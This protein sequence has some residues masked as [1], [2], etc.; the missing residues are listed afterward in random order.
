MCWEGRE[1]IRALSSSKVCVSARVP[2]C[3]FGR[4]F[5]FL[6]FG[7]SKHDPPR[8]CGTLVWDRPSCIE[9]V[10]RLVIAADALVPFCAFK[11]DLQGILGCLREIRKHISRHTSEMRFVLLCFLRQVGVANLIYHTSFFLSADFTLSTFRFAEH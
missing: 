9:N 3:Y 1:S 4:A 2:R 11:D 6:D 8:I 5:L 10:P 7:A